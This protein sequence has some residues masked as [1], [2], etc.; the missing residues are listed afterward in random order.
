MSLSSHAALLSS[1]LEAIRTGRD[2]LL[3]QV[4]AL[5]VLSKTVQTEYN[6]LRNDALPISRLPE[7]ILSFIFETGHGDYPVGSSI[8][9]GPSTYHEP[10]TYHRFEISVLHVSRRWREV[11]FRT[12]RI[13]TNICRVQ[14][15]KSLDSIAAYLER[16]K[17]VG[18]DIQ[19][20]TDISDN[21]TPFCQLLNSHCGQCHSL[22]ISSFW[23]NLVEILNC[24]STTL[25]SINIQSTFS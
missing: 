4:S 15:Q 23:E 10:S 2:G 9:R 6:G 3:C 18:L 11:A 8:Y 16:S 22:S 21:I 5:D 12:P 17:A 25:H 20:S 19:I 14:H 1:L 13:W 7:E 24:F